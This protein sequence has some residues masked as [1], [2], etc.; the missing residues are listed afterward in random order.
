MKIAVI[1][2]SPKKSDSASATLLK[3][4]KT[5]FPKEISFIDYDLRVSTISP[6]II[7]EFNQFDAL[8]FAFP[9]YVDGVP[10]HLLSCLCEIEAYG[11]ENKAIH[12]YAIANCGFYEGKQ[13][14]N[15]LHIMQNWCEKV[16]L[17]W[18]QGIGVGGGGALSGLGQVPLGRG[19]KKNLGTAFNQLAAHIMAGTS[20]DNI[21]LSINFPR[22]LYKWAGQM[23]W[24]QLIKA[25][26]LKVKDL[27]RRL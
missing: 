2:G 25:N 3:D 6:D 10:S 21:Y 24:R 13:N 11:I 18:G 7:E 27:G 19:P 8:V 20:A 15:A 5:C 23:G 12:V 22:F 16:G 1:N 26:K 4:L 17:I 14:I 9:L